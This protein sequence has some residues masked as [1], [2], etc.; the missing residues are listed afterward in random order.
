M[1]KLLYLLWKKEGQSLLDFKKLLLG[2][3]LDEVSAAGGHGV[4]AN[5]ADEDV[6]T[7]KFSINNSGLYPDAVLSVWVDTAVFHEQLTTLVAAQV[8]RVAAYL[9]R[10]SEPITNTEQRVLLGQRTSGFAQV[11]FLAKPDWLSD[12][13]WLHQWHSGHTPIAIDTQSTFRYVQNVVIKALTFAAPQIDAVIEEC[14]PQEA[15]T[16]MHAFYDAEGDDQKLQ[17]NAQLMAE[18]CQKFI[19]MSR[20]D[21]MATSEYILK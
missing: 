3:M 2:A 4:Q 11:V 16:S 5:I 8:G 18:S 21:C 15:L 1:E 14:F 9:V 6:D 10:S 12:E 7:F 19:D 17:K 13:A 20:I